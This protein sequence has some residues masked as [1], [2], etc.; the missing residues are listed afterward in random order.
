MWNKLNYTKVSLK[1]RLGI[2]NATVNVQHNVTY[3]M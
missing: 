3:T 2:I 1:I